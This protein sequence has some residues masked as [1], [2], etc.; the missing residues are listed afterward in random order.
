MS[1][2]HDM[3]DAERFQRL[4]VTPVVD[5][6]AARLEPLVTRVAD[7]E[8]RLDRTEKKIGKITKVYTGF[9]AVCTFLGHL[10]WS[11]FQ[12]KV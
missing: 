5:Q 1:F 9:V 12:K 4:F 7:V 6:L 10:M 8:R 2:P 3:E 11:K